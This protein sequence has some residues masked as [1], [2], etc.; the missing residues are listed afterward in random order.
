MKEYKMSN[1]F[2]ISFSIILNT[3]SRT[4]SRHSSVLGKDS[5]SLLD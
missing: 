5:H 1:I 4:D 3:T 2:L